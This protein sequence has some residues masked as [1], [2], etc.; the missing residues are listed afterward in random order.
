[1]SHIHT[2]LHKHTQVLSHRKFFFILSDK[3]FHL[4]LYTEWKLKGLHSSLDR[5][6]FKNVTTTLILNEPPFRVRCPF[7]GTISYPEFF[8]S[9]TAHTRLFHCLT[10]EQE[11][12]SI[13][14]FCPDH[15]VFKNN[16]HDLCIKALSE[17]FNT[18]HATSFP[19][20]INKCSINNRSCS[21]TTHLHEIH[22]AI[23]ESTSRGIF[24]QIRSVS[25][26]QTG[27][28]YNGNMSLVS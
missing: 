18:S 12:G 7:F 25:G 27:Y 5:H 23:T 17:L 24:P 19:Q 22:R 8:M 16:H 10:L 11:L 3:C 1:M 26:E 9:V 6:S 15:T 20:S 28:F 2:Y 13:I 21:T 14:T 4:E